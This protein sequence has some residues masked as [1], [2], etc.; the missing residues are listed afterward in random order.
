M[1]NI[2]NHNIKQKH[3]SFYQIA[4]YDVLM[5]EFETLINQFVLR[6]VSQHELESIRHAIIALRRIIEE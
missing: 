5:G 6:Q 1:G 4:D 3:K 2:C